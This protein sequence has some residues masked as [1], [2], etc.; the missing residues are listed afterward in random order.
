MT[1]AK[2]SPR[3]RRQLRPGAFILALV[4]LAGLIG[5]T[6]PW[7][8]QQRQASIQTE[9]LNKLRQIGSALSAFDSEYGIFPDNNTPEEVKENTGTAL[10]LS[11]PNSN[12]YFRQLIA[13]DLAPEHAFW[14]KTSFSLK[15]PDN[16][17]D[18]P[19]RALEAG[20]VGFSYVMITQTD[21]QSS[22]GD[23]A[24]AVVIAP[25]YKA[26][27][28]WTFDPKPFGG[29]ALVLRLDN[30]AITVPIGPDRTAPIRTSANYRDS[31]GRVRIG[32]GTPWGLDME[33]VLRAPL[34]A[35]DQD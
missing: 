21:G 16:I 6:I 31:D 23:P 25:S 20:E 18:P 4:L 11:G 17:T 7:V 35:I 2:P 27:T 3:P 5:A 28:D 14:C 13:K 33:P 1:P 32:E 19:G 9:A 8:G 22:S 12:D 10:I 26:R 15:S 29:K 24:R 30:G 34:P